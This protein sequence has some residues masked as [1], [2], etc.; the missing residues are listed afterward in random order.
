MDVIHGGPF[1]N[2]W[3]ENDMKTV[4]LFLEPLPIQIRFDANHSSDAQAFLQCV[5]CSSKAA[6]SHA[7][8][9]QDLLC[10]LGVTPE[11][12]NHPLFETMLTFH[13]RQDALTF[14]M[15]GTTTL[16]TWSNGAK[17]GLMCEFTSLPDGRILL[18][19]EYDDSVW[20]ELEIS[21]IERSITVSLEVLAHNSSYTDMI[22][23]L[24][25]T[26]GQ[27]V[28]PLEKEPSSLNLVNYRLL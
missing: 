18:R 1:A 28:E 17:F 27:P 14:S 13:E 3:S 10:H 2:R 22:N 19:L 20:D 5:L 25:G 9:W 6:L 15:D 7:V 26:T 8:P 11:Y 23:T 16:L 24:R 21:R 12:P 4:G